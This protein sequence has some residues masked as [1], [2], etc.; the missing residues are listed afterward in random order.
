MIIGT[1]QKYKEKEKLFGKEICVCWRICWRVLWNADGALALRSSG[2]K[3]NY[4][5]LIWLRRRIIKQMVVYDIGERKEIEMDFSLS[6]SPHPTAPLG[7]E[8]TSRRRRFQFD[9]MAAKTNKQSRVEKG[10]QASCGRQPRFDG[11]AVNYYRWQLTDVVVGTLVAVAPPP[12]CSG[13]L[14][15]SQSGEV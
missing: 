10:S 6:L 8:H 5:K 3:W 2:R 13:K 12:L 1:R 11:L 9:Q 4:P 15:H 7:E 14:L